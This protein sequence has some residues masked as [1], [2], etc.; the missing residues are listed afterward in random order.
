MELA[1]PGYIMSS[2]LQYNSSITFHG[3][4]MIF[5]MIMPLLMGGMGNILLPIL[6]RCSDMIFPRMNGLSL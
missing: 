5:F 2:A 1:L 3:I 6:L 4:F